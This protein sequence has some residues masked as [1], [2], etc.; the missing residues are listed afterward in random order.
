MR[1]TSSAK[2]FCV[3]F[4]SMSRRQLGTVTVLPSSLKPRSVSILRMVSPSMSVPSIQLTRSTS[5]SRTSGSGGFGNT[6]MTPS[7]TSPAPSSST[8]SQARL[9]ARMVR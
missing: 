5:S 3:Y 9:T 4:G 6:S 1:A 2:S 8:S 7:T